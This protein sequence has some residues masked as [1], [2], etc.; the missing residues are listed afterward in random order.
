MKIEVAEDAETS[1]VLLVFFVAKLAAIIAEVRT[2]VIEDA[3]ERL[4][5]LV[6]VVSRGMWSVNKDV[7]LAR[8]G[9][10]IQEHLQLAPLVGYLLREIL[11]HEMADVLDLCESH[12]GL[13]VLIREEAPIHVL[14]L[15]VAAIVTRY[16]TVR[17]HHRQNPELE[18]LPQL[19]RE[20]ITLKQKVYEA[21]NDEARVRLSRMLPTQDHDRWLERILLL[22]RIRYFQQRDVDA[23]ITL[24]NAGELDE[25]EGRCLRHGL[26]LVDVRLQL[27]VGV[28]YRVR[29]VYLILFELKFEVKAHAVVGLGLVRI[30]FVD[31]HVVW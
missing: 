21:M 17:V 20:D 15:S 31:F 23:S 5:F 28:R 26:D 12:L 8:M 18:V 24:P 16:D 7:S 11:L 4:D 6:C 27:R 9:V 19:V 14:A 29:N 25:L 10:N 3:R 2:D 30:H 22:V 13:W 1:A